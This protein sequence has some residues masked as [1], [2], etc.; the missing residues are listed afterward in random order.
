MSIKYKIGK[1]P[2]NKV[3]GTF[4]MKDLEL[5]DEYKTMTLNKIAKLLKEHCKTKG[6]AEIELHSIRF[7]IQTEWIKDQ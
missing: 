1:G 2:G 6:N 5:K 3:T 4:G 7:T